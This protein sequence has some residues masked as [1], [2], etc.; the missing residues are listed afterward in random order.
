M[1]CRRWLRAVTR[2]GTVLG[3]RS[4]GAVMVSRT[5]VHSDGPEFNF[6]LYGLS[7][8]EA[9]VVMSDGR[10]LEKVGVTPDELVLPTPDDLAAGRDPVLAKAAALL[11]ITLTPEAAATLYDSASKKSA[12]R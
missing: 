1:A 3:D 6:V 9:D 4:A 12:G 2:R 8:T 5:W 11:G 7:I 10:R